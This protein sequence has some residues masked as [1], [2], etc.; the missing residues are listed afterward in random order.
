MENSHMVEFERQRREYAG[1]SHN[2]LK[3]VELRGCVC[4]INAIELASNILRNANSLQ[5]ITF[6]SRNRFYIG[7]GGWTEGCDSCWFD[8]NLIHKMLQDDV[9]EQCRLVIL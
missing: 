4:T 8:K 7:A 6:T 1:F 9:N 3:Y 2:D 5:Q